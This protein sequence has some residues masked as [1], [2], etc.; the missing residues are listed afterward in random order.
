MVQGAALTVAPHPGQVEDPPLARRK[1]L[2]AG[3]LRRGVQV[4]PPRGA[5]WRDDL[6]GEGVQ[7]R[8]VPGR[9]LQG[10]RL[11]FQELPVLE[12]APDSAHDP[13]AGQEER[14]PVGVDVWAPPGRGLKGL[15]G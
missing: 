10:R 4:E 8:L 15:H 5:V 1:Q 12:P 7:V 2:L 3:E 14:P 11:D 6:G 13:A 9:D